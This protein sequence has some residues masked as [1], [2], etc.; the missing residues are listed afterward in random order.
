MLRPMT[1]ATS[2]EQAVLVGFNL[3]N[4]LFFIKNALQSLD[5]KT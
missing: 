3:L 4:L 2:Q 5:R 1:F